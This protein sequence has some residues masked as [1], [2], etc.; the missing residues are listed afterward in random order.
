[1]EETNPS[2]SQVILFQRIKESLP[3]N[4]SLVDELADLLNMS[5]DSV[6]RRLRGETALTVDELAL[7]CKAYKFSFD[8]FLNSTSLGVIT[9]KYAPL[10]NTLAS[11]KEYL[12]RINKDMSRYKMAKEKDIVYAAVDVP[13]FHH[14][15]QREMAAFKIFYWVRSIL[16]VEEYQD[17]KFSLDAVG[18]EILD[19]AE[20]IYE[21][22][23]G[24]SSTEIW[25]DDTLNTTLK[26]IEFYWDSGM[27]KSKEDALTI[28]TQL[29][30]I[31]ERLNKQAELGL[32]INRAGQ[33]VN[34]NVVFNLYQADVMI[35]NNSILI[36]MD[37]VR[38]TYITF[39]TF[40]ALATMSPTFC[41]ETDVWNRN[42]IQK[43]NLISG[44]AGKQ[45][46]RFFNHNMTNLNKLVERIKG[47]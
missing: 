25:S 43:S 38:I 20:S 29:E 39:N 3:N 36:S 37:G 24:I 19:L 47:D 9:F 42:L 1:M 28:C 8:E 16:D 44:V 6:Y 11:Y 46:Y 17:R 41:D 12:Q 40:N 2:N 14:F 31:L 5:N 22:Y 15:S 23:E 34:S 18:D 32:K 4:I 10:N 27:F 45:R 7:I 33:V 26:Q 35:G 13:L 30:L 21:N